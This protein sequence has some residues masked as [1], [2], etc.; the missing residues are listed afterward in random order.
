MVTYFPA[1]TGAGAPNLHRRDFMLM[2]MLM[3]MVMVMVSRGATYH[4]SFSILRTTTWV[5]RVMI[6]VGPQ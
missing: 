3:L 5:S 4:S 2:F 6:P 1:L